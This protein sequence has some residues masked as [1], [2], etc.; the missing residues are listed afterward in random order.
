L[1]WEVGYRE[2][3]LKDLRKLPKARREKIEKIVFKA[4]PNCKNPFQMGILEKL[5]GYENYYKIRV[6]NYRI[7]LEIDIAKKNLIFCRVLHRKDIYRY[8]P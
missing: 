5:S 8:Y 3:F 4:I 2:I 6:G 7:G 1:N